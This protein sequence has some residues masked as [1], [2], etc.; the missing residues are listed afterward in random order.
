MREAIVQTKKVETRPKETPAPAPVSVD[1]GK[2]TDISEEDAELH[3][4]TSKMREK[5]SRFEKFPRFSRP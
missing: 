5:P 4:R 1:H 3:L 2:R